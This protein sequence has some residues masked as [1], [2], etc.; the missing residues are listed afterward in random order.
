MKKRLLLLV[1]PLVL[2]VSSCQVRLNGASIPDNLKTINV[3]Y[4]ENDAPLVVNNLSQV[5]TEALKD[6][7]RTTTKLIIVRGEADATLEG[8]IT[9]YSFAPVA[10]QA[11]A[12]NRAP[13]AGQ[14]RLTISVSVTYTSPEKKNDFKNVTFS[15]Y[16]DFTGDPAPQ[17]QTLIQGIN[18]QL[19]ED[20]FNKAFAN[21]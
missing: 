16:M 1:L 19:T 17:E 8:I 5:F 14:T 10:I 2:L 15:R 6:K 21:W 7:I 9:S 3:K 13:V 20:I 12:D 18:K 4:F 11:T